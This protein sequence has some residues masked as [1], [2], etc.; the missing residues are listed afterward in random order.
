MV[1][2]TEDSNRNAKLRRFI[3]MGLL[4]T[5]LLILGNS[6]LVP[7]SYAKVQG[8]AL[9]PQSFHS[10]AEMASPAVVNIRTVKILKGGGPVFRHFHRGPWGKDDPFNEFFERF[11]GDQ[12]RCRFL[13]RYL[14]IGWLHENH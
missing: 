6:Q 7:E 2:M 13:P 8:T 11:F 3:M 9:V 5:G 1:G 14:V 10:L 4:I 12:F